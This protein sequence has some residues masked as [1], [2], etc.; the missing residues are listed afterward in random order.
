MYSNI[1]QRV[2]WTRVV[3][4]GAIHCNGAIIRWVRKTVYMYLI[5]LIS[6]GVC[7]DNEY[8]HS[9]IYRINYCGILTLYFINVDLYIEP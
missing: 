7:F 3:T 1:F 8:Y 4:A 2:C 9:L 5:L 6:S